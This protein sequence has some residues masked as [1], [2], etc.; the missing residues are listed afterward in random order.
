[1]LLRRQQRQLLL[2]LQGLKW[3]LAGPWVLLLRAT[4]LLLLPVG[5]L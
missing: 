5:Q 3:S 4:P 1:M 2:W